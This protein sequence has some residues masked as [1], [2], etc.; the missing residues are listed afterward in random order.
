MSWLL[1]KNTRGI[2]CGYSRWSLHCFKLPVSDHI[3]CSCP[4]SWKNLLTTSDLSQLPDTNIDSFLPVFVS[5]SS[6]VFLL[7][8]FIRIIH[9]PSVSSCSHTLISSGSP[10]P[11][12]YL[13]CSSL[14]PYPSFLINL[15]SFLLGSCPDTKPFRHFLITSVH[16]HLFHSW[17]YSASSHL[18][19][20][21]TSPPHL[22]PIYTYSISPP[23]TMIEHLEPC[24]SASHPVLFPP[25]LLDTQTVPLPYLDHAKQMSFPVIVPTVVDSALP[26]SCLTTDFS[27]SSPPSTCT[28]TISTSTSSYC[29]LRPRVMA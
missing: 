8:I 25:G 18:T 16:R 23:F 12:S 11:C 1:L 7:F 20:L 15:P 3:S 14:Q 17:R 21:R 5:S 13:F 9:T 19:H 2:V 29:L 26:P 22:T 27:S 28:S 6:S 10:L 4:V 24:C